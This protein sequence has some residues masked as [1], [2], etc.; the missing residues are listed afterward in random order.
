VA[1]AMTK[2]KTRKAPYAMGVASATWATWSG[3]ERIRSVH[4]SIEET[5][6]ARQ[7]RV[8]SVH[9]R[10]LAAERAGTAAASVACAFLT[11]KLVDSGSG[12]QAVPRRHVQRC[13][14]QVT[15]CVILAP[16]RHAEATATGMLQPRPLHGSTKVST[17]TVRTSTGSAATSSAARDSPAASRVAAPAVGRG[18]AEQVSAARDGKNSPPRGSHQHT[19]RAR[20]RR[21]QHGMCCFPAPAAL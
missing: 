11:D 8:C 13:A 9:E 10:E 16:L 18:D 17:K 15:P 14:L 4:T 7:K 2:K 1:L 20:T 19:P 21:Q 3:Q 5:K 12:S 6:P